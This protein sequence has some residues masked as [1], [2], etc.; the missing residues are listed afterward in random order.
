VR[1]TRL[2][3]PDV[4]L[5]EPARLTDARGH[6][7]ETY[8]A[9]RYAEFGVTGP[10]VQDNVSW[11]GARVLR[12]LHYQEPNAQGKLVGVLVGEAFDVAVD[13]RVGSPTF[14]RWV[15]EQLSATNGR[16]LWIPPGFAHG[17]VVTGAEALF[18]YKCTGYY[19]AASERSLRWDDPALGITWPVAD[20]ILSAK[21][22]A[23]PLLAS[24]PREHLPSVP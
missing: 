5:F 18:A 9:R 14:G 12:G 3:L 6:F 2:A 16:Q 13:I 17:F 23:A 19:D 11:S 20:P 21:D 22:A 10:F 15:G 7:E 1:A 4:L 24:V 8:S